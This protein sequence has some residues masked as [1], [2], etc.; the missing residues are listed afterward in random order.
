MTLVKN[1]SENSI[2]MEKIWE[3]SHFLKHRKIPICLKRKIMDRVILPA[4]TDGADVDSNK[5]SGEEGGSGPMKHGEIAA[6]HCQERQD[7]E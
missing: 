3:Y 5:T 2:R 6:K 7:P 1:T 4:M